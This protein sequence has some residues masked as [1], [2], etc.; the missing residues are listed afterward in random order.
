MSRMGS[1][2]VLGM[3][4]LLA[5][6][7]QLP[8]GPDLRIRI[9][10]VID[11]T[12]SIANP[13]WPAAVD[14][15]VAHANDGL[16]AADL[17]F[18]FLFQAEH[19]DSTNTPSVAV[20]RAE[21]LVRRLG[22]KALITDTSADTIAVNML[23]YDGDPEN[24][25]NV[26][27][28]CQACTSPDINNPFAVRMN[29]VEQAALR[30]GL[31]WC[32]RSTMDSDPQATVLL[33]VATAQGVR[34]D[35]NGDG[36]FKYSVMAIDD[37]Y[38]RGFADGLERALAG[39]NLTPAPSHERVL[40]DRTATPDTLDW[41][42]VIS[43]LTDDRNQQNPEVVDGR[44]DIIFA[45]D[46]PQFAAAFTA[47]W[48]NA[49]SPI[50]LM[51]THNFRHDSVAVKLG[52]KVI[53]QEGTSHVVLDGGPSGETFKQ[54]FSDAHHR[55]PALWASNSYDSAMTL[56]L[57]TLIALR[58][59]QLDNSTGI[60]GAEIRDAMSEVNDPRGEVVRSGPESFRD[61]VRHIHDS[62]PIN[63]EGASGPMD[64]DAQGNV[65]G[66]IAHFKFESG[67]FEDRA[68]YDCVA[69]RNSCPQEGL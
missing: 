28:I 17:P 10:S 9:G 15:A 16:M 58:R 37:A 3:S 41:A 32:F 62:R 5:A 56:M 61:A 18:D 54:A 48:L 35:V 68:T 40:H 50:R 53:G 39:L 43:E 63:Y 42:K 47:E 30:N 27:V 6:C 12:G 8:I 7:R 13:A 24:D 14:L 31:K 60:T 45:V 38:G 2:A 34:G 57:A 1:V 19:S 46:F 44:P 36:H 49:E 23:M 64:F 25:L 66:R 33:A 20:K 51:H 65:Q 52:A 11:R 21:D 4:L 29:A 22:V 67:G 69:N 55:A 26:P 59:A